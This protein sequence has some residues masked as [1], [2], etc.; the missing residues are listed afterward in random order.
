MFL[1]LLAVLAESQSTTMVSLLLE[2]KIATHN[3]VSTWEKYPLV[4]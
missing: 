4:L 1:L 2:I 3:C